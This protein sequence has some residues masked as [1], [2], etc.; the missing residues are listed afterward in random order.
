MKK[1]YLTDRQ[2][3]VVC[4]YKQGGY[5]I[6]FKQLTED[7]YMMMATKDGK[8]VNLL[9]VTQEQ[10]YPFLEDNNQ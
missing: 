8:E 9:K 2:W 10:L 4:N 5:V 7:T 1:N 3:N 6:L